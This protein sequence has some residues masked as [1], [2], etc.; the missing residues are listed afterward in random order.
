MSEQNSVEP[1][2]VPITK[3]P[4]DEVQIGDWYWVHD[5][6]HHTGEYT[7]QGSYEYKDE[8][9][10]MCV[11]HIGSNFVEFTIYEYHSNGSGFCTMKVH[12]DDFFKETRP[13]PNWRSILQGRMDDLQK[14]M[15]EKTQELVEKGKALCLLK[16]S[17]AATG[18][19]PQEE[20]LLP[21]RVSVD[22]KGHKAALVAL[23][24]SLP[25]ISKDI[26]KLGK[27]FSCSA[28]NISLTDVVN[29][30]RV[31]NSLA[32]VEDRIFTVELYCGL[33]EQVV[34]IAD[35][36]P[37]PED[38][39]I[40]VRQLMLFMDEETLWDYESGGMDYESLEKFDAWIVKPGNLERLLPERRGV[41][42]FKVRRYEKNYGP[43]DSMLEA[44]TNVCKNE[45]N[46]TTYL[47]LRNGGKVYR[48]ASAVDFSPRLV[49]FKDEI[50]EKQFQR[51]HRAY[52]G[53]DEHGW[54]T[55]EYEVVEA[56]TPKDIDYDEHVEKLDSTMKHYN[57]MVILL[58]GLL[59][60]SEVFTPHPQINLCKAES[61][62]HW[63]KLVRDEEMALP[64]PKL[65][66][67][68]YQKQLNRNLQV[69]TWI[70]ID[71]L[72][73]I[74]FKDQHGKEFSDHYRWNTRY[75]KDHYGNPMPRVIQITGVKRDKSQVKVSWPRERSRGHRDRWTGRWVDTT[76]RMY[77]EWV[78]VDMVLN[79]DVYT[80]GDYRIFLFNHAQKVEYRKWAKYLLTAEDWTQKRAKG[81][82]DDE[83]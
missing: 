79:L 26:E 62:A 53:V 5:E 47:L 68:E 61:F 38:E 75:I 80:P 35:G 65:S 23:R 43:V 40:S 29:L 67:E 1:I 22:P 50:G 41:V 24:D 57:R 46:M 12:F 28:R 34:K 2:R 37:A 27:K 42:A 63:V 81:K 31:Q 9:V 18:P 73:F 69:G 14:Q 10:L 3:L 39:P 55:K 72:K 21:V 78:P 8:E 70:Y 48:I 71:H 60:R 33:Q 77:H 32:I 17:P 45:A 74:E 44:W 59:D 54:P 82:V 56:V 51:R 52:A 83:E 49:P 19:A 58:Q 7:P 11:K 20:T 36:E 76:D 66:F 25:G 6:K 13:E 16:E 30:Q 64:G 4:Q 15:R